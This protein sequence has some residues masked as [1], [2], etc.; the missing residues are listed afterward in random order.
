MGVPKTGSKKLDHSSFYAMHRFEAR[1][2]AAPTEHSETVF[3][4]AAIDLAGGRG[5]SER[6]QYVNVLMCQG[7]GSA[8]VD[9]GS[10]PGLQESWVPDRA[11]QGMR[12]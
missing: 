11:E 3:Y 2:G 9:C 12:A 10:E 6:F 1:A 8:G 5:C 4:S 7:D